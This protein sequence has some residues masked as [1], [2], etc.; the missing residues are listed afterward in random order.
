MPLSRLSATLPTA[1]LTTV[2]LIAAAPA[3]ALAAHDRAPALAAHDRAPALAAG[4]TVPALAAD[5]PAPVSAEI[6]SAAGDGCV[7]PAVRLAD[8]Y[9]SVEAQSGLDS[10]LM[11]RSLPDQASVQT[12]CAVAVRIRLD[13]PAR[14]KPAQYLMAGSANLPA[15]T[16]AEHYFESSFDGTQWYGQRN[17]GGSGPFVQGGGSVTDPWSADCAPAFDVLFRVGLSLTATDGAGGVGSVEL[18]APDGA[19]AELRTSRCG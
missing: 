7:E 5:N 16:R 17:A 14:L 6:L 11:L 2:C 19:V 9:L 3:P 15:G 13:Q 1:A 8:G 4:T 12:E 10:S 18:R